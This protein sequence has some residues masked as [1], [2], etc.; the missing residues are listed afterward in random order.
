MQIE[1]L[2]VLERPEPVGSGLLLFDLRV[3]E[4]APPA[5]SP[6]ADPPLRVGLAMQRGLGIANQDVE[7]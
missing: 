6:I 1:E 4:T 2:G 7:S 5:V 3:V